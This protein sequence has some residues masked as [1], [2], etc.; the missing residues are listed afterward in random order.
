M[1]EN[2]AKYNVDYLNVGFHIGSPM[3]EGRVENILFL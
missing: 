1:L 3:K 2:V